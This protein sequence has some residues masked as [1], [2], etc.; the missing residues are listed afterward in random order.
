MS[1]RKQHVLLVATHPTQ[2]G[3][4]VFRLLA[5]DP[6]VQIQVAYCSLQGAKAGFDEEFG[7]EVQWDVPL[8][9][10]YP[11]V[12]LQNRAR[13]P[14]LG[15]FWGLLN[16]GLWKLIR[17]RKFDAVVLYTGYRY[18]SF[19]I[20]LL[21]AK[22]SKTAALFGT[23][24]P[25]LD[26]R[27]GR[28][29]KRPLKR[30][31]WPALFHL[32]DSVIVPS[33]SGVDL[34]RSL[35]IPESR[36]VLTPY[37]V[38]N[39]RWSQAAA[40]V[41]RGAARARWGIPESAKVVVFSAK[42]QPWKR[43][44]DALRGFAR[45]GVHG[46][47]LLFAGEGP[48]RS[49]IE[50]EIDR[51]ALKDRVKLLGFVNQSALPEVY[52]TAEVLVLTS[53]YEPFGVVVNEA[54]LCGCVPILSDRVGARRDLVD[55]GKTGFVFPC[56]DV[57]SLAALLKEVLADPA[58]LQTMRESAVEKIAGWSPEL[59]V[60]RLLQAI[61]RGAALVAGHHAERGPRKEAHQS[62]FRGI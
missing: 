14:G 38:D 23:D 41:E 49:E 40:R 2:Y 10:G 52:G 18:A 39:Q 28:A 9:D 3:A 62:P 56:G 35:G 26:P 31:L 59:N 8:L 7:R 43:P 27:D 12:E 32:A 19:W 25:T 47:F 58:R 55:P 30:L 34:M 51:L 50:A 61:E 1:D 54:M 4:P 46:S 21:A 29:W 42:L 22:A 57:E 11:W 44:L 20:G 13:R 45:A 15:R 48:L 36:I 33:S 37:A 17:D 60:N 53:E 24:A 5:R 16:P 6:R